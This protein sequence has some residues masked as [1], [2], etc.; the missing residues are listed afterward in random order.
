MK[1]RLL[2]T[3]LLACASIV[4]G[5]AA[6]SDAALADRKTESGESELG[7]D[8]RTLRD[9][10]NDIYGRLQADEGIRPAPIVDD[11]RFLR[12]VYL[13]LL[14]KPPTAEEAARFNPGSRDSRG[15]RG[16]EKREALVDELLQR[17]E[18][19]EH[20]ATWWQVVMVGRQG[21]GRYRGM[22]RNW[23][24]TQIENERPFHE[25]VHDILSVDGT[26]V[27]RPEMGYLLMFQND[28][29][30]MAGE[31]SRIFMG[32]QIQ[33]AECHDHPYEDWREDD[34]ESFLGFFRLF[35]TSQ[36]DIDDERHWRTNDTA[37][38]SL[39]DVERRL[40]LRGRY[41][42]PRYLAGESYEFDADKSLRHS[43]ADWMTSPDNPWFR[44]MTVNR[45]MAY[46]LGVGFISPVDDF[47]SLNMPVYPIILNMLGRDFAASG[48]DMKYLIRGIVNSE[49]YQRDVA[50]NRTNRNDRA[51]HSRQ[52][53]RRLSPEQIERTILHVTGIERLNP[54]PE[55]RDV[56]R[57]R[58]TPQE[59]E[60]AAVRNRV[61]AYRNNLRRA[62]N[63]AWGADPVVRDV[64]DYDGSIL[65]ALMFMNSDLLGPPQ[66]N[67]SLKQILE[68]HQGRNERVNAIFLTVLGRHPTARDAAVVDSLFR[69]RRVTDELYE[70]L[71]VGLMSTTEFVVNH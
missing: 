25:L 34:F 29:P 48:F 56:P 9:G 4:F 61:Q 31:T 38:N 15:R 20:F 51:F 19:A 18:F 2:L 49:L 46:F 11:H 37:V 3:G 39:D 24:Q 64:D 54:Y 27:E 21:S 30:A 47:N 67:N 55:I 6:F 63:D 28:R 23:L 40:R 52:F 65:Q 44:E 59:R 22:L 35:R 60:W 32:R 14:G 5:V 17:P 68:T 13:D 50:L 41:K 1:L 10:L 33:C 69:G 43:L 58:M 12:R 62:I 45:M 16:A 71:F 53:V 66:L 8:W 57:E 42:V 7:K 36:V 26:T 70:D